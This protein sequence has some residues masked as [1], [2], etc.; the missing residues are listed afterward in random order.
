MK[1]ILIANNQSLIDNKQFIDFDLPLED[2]DLVILFNKLLPMK[3]EKIKKHKNK[4]LF[5]RNFNWWFELQKDKN[6]IIFDRSKIF[7]DNHKYFNK[8]YFID[9]DGFNNN[10]LTESSVQ[11]S[12]V[13]DFLKSINFDFQKLE[14]ISDKISDLKEFTYI[15]KIPT[16]G[17]VAYLWIKYFLAKPED[18][19]ILLG[20]TGENVWDG[21]DTDWEKNYYLNDIKNLKKIKII[22]E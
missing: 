12:G 21:H 18:E 8:I 2:N 14:I 3:W 6:E 7:K 22:N 17:F 16:T 4:H 20:F 5:L 9:G 11:E 13:K 10:K 1:Y 19:I 15:N